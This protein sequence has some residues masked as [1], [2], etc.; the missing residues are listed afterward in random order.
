MS[1]SFGESERAFSFPLYLGGEA[2]RVLLGD[3]GEAFR[4][5]FGDGEVRAGKIDIRFTG[6]GV[7]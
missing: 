1:G 5:L 6:V 3:G 4:R 2:F 7:F